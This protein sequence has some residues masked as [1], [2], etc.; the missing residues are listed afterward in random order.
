MRRFLPLVLLTAT[1]CFPLGVVLPLVTV[2]R[3]LIFTDEP[4]L[5]GIVGG[6][7]NSGD[8]LL[9]ALIALFS[10]IFPTVK[11]AF[12]HNAAYREGAV[13]FPSWLKVLSNWSMLD[14]VLVAL[15]IFA[16]KTSGL[17]TAFAKPGLWFFAVSVLLTAFAASLVRSEQES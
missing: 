4:S 14:V 8:F 2:E 16:A 7:W 10:L 5:V 17:A 3:L 6:L 9:A 12:L 15:V 13:Q 11:L 1:L